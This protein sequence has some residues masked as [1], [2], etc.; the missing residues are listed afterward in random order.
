MSIGIPSIPYEF[1]GLSEE[2]EDE[3]WIEISDYLYLKKIIFLG[4]ELDDEIT[5]DILAILYFFDHTN[6]ETFT[7]NQ[8][9]TNET[10]YNR[11]KKKSNS[12]DIWFYIN[13]QR[14]KSLNGFDTLSNGLAIYNSM[15]LI[16]S[17]EI[18][19][20]CVGIAATPASLLLAAGEPGKRLAVSYS[21][22][23]I[24]NARSS[25]LGQAA[26]LDIQLKEDYIFYNIITTIYAECTG[27]T[28]NKIKQDMKS[29]LSLSAQE[30]KD[31]GF[32]DEIILDSNSPFFSIT[33][34]KK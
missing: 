21:R 34:K 23:V 25:I 14:D 15:E 3:E 9:Q 5:N 22:I 18:T 26:A 1:P 31:Y 7:N 4:H 17:T 28:K 32:I 16:E 33:K 29:K 19:T 12:N 2:E 20:Y 10:T 8:N 27:K 13:S 11:N 30:A 6:I 24:N